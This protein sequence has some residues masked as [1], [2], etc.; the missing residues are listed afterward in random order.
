[1]ADRAR[2]SAVHISAVIRGLASSA[3]LAA[4]PPDVGQVLVAFHD[5]QRIRVDTGGRHRVP[6]ADDAFALHVERRRP[7][8]FGVDQAL[9][10][11]AA[12]PHG[13]QP[14]LAVP[15]PEH[16]VGEL[17]H[18]RPVVDA[19]P[20][21]SG[22]VFG[23]VDHHDGQAPLQHHL[24]VGIVVADRIHHEAVHPGAEHG[25]RS[26]LEA[27]AGLRRRPAAVPARALRTIGPLPQRNPAPP[28][29]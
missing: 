15:Q 16:V 17:A 12:Q 13:Q 28:G 21:H 3:A 14:D 23:L 9:A 8:P 2:M 25:G 1:M 18:R 26:V 29:R 24:Q 11:V 7:Q 19:H 6:H 20:G 22:Q 4:S 5:G 27:P 10:A